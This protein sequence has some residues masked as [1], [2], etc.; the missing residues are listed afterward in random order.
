MFNFTDIT[1][2]K[3]QKLDEEKLKREI[4]ANSKLK[5]INVAVHHETEF[6]LN[7]NVQL[8]ERLLKN[9]KNKEQK[10]MVQIILASN[11]LVMFHLSDL[12]NYRLIKTGILTPSYRLG[13]V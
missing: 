3:Q 7:T 1:H 10:R 4:E 13:D 8:C 2:E 9:L 5:N 12:V 11:W 6:P